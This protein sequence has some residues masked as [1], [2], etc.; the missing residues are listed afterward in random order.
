MGTILNGDTNLR[1]LFLPQRP[2]R[3]YYQTATQ[4]PA[5]ARPRPNTTNP[6]KEGNDDHHKNTTGQQYHRSPVEGLAVG[7]ITGTI[8]VF[9]LLLRHVT[10]E[11]PKDNWSYDIFFFAM[12]LP[13]L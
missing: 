1:E 5:T 2:R 3:S 13:S 9:F 6:S 8:W 12:H 7:A 11:V 4:Q 10:F